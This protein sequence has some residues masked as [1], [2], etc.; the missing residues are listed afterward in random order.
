MSTPPPYTRRMIC[1]VARA[2]LIDAIEQYQGARLVAC[3]P[4]RSTRGVNRRFAGIN[5]Q[6]TPTRRKNPYALRFSDQYRTASPIRRGVTFEVRQNM[7]DDDISRCIRD[8]SDRIVCNKSLQIRT[9][10]EIRVKHTAGIY[11]NDDD[12]DC[13]FRPAGEGPPA[14]FCVSQVLSNLRTI[15][16]LY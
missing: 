5:T 7:S 6:S 10:N 16:P 11:Q 14:R 15:D 3:P 13:S 12:S 2:V 1:L 4:R 9:L 8:T